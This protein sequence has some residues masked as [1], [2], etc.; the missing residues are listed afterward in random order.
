MVFSEQVLHVF[1][2]FIT[3]YIVFDAI[4]KGIQ[5]LLFPNCFSARI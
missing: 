3:E 5:K 2:D 4:A 1:I